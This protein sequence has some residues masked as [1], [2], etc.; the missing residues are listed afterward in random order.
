MTRYAD[1]D[2]CP[3]C[4]ATITPGA[5][6][7]G[8]CALTLRG[9]TARR[10]FVTLSQADTLL[11]TLRAA[12]VPTAVPS[13][14]P[15]A[16]T[17]ASD[18]GPAPAASPAFAARSAGGPRPGLSATSVPKLLLGLG[19]GCLL[20][21]AL[22]FLAVTWSVMGVGGR[23]ATLVAFT[24]I[25]GGLSAW[26]VGRKLRGAAESLALVG[27]GLLALDVVGADNAGWFGDPSAAALLVVVG[28]VLAGTGTAG[29][30]AVRRTTVGLTTPEVA[31]L[32]GTALASLGAGAGEWFSLSASLLAACLVGVAVTVAAHGLRMRTATVGAGLV[33]LL[34]WLALTGHSFDRAVQ[35]ASWHELWVDLEVWPLLVSCALAAGVA[36]VRALPVSARVTAASIAELVAV[37][38]LAI[39]VVDQGATEAA[40]AGI[41]ALALTG[42]ASRLLPSRWKL[43]STAVQLV[44]GL[45]LLA[46]VAGQGSSAVERLFE[47]A[48]PVWTGSGGDRLSVW[49][50]PGQPAAWLLPLAAVA[51]LGTLWVQAEASR[52]MDRVLSPVADLR[53]LAAL[54]AASLVGALALYPVPVW[55]VLAAVLLVA[56]GFTGWWLFAGSIVPL[57]PAT[58][59]MVSAVIVSLHSDGLTA[60][61]IGVVLAAGGVV[62]L[63]ARSTTLSAVAGATAASALAGLVWTVGHLL[64]V[65][66]VSVAL[67]A[68]LLLGVV[69]LVAPYAPDRWWAAGSP[70]LSRSGLE[71]GAGAAG[72]PLVMAGVA[73]A[74]QSEAATWLAV[75]LTV[76]G[77]VVTVMSLLRSD[78]RTL[79][80]AGGALL[81]LASWVRLWDIGV[82]A[83]EAYTLP[84]AAVLLVVGLLH[85][86]RTPEA[87]TMTALTPALSLALVP[88]LLWALTEPA[89]WRA[90]L[91]GLGCLALVLAGARLG[92]TA[93]MTVGAAVGGLLVLRLA[94]PYIG[95]AVPRWVLI[96]A[97]GALLIAV[98]ATWE[99]RLTDARQLMGYVRALR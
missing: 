57:A 66:P 36:A 52:L 15:A 72:V 48:G 43:S 97:A 76:A 24:A 17:S 93:P 7:C 11:A 88:S 89:G 33:A 58:I 73:L 63:R 34:G 60:V 35:H 25:A 65:E 19:A 62:H 95:E 96:G 5:S 46:L 21:A 31:V 38:A 30:L 18:V 20:V 84:S 14:T 28:A 22:V 53:V 44:A 69:A 81:A 41:A 8:T 80:W 47:A 45:G 9:E 40:L 49:A 68:L 42:L 10:L 79:G 13:V 23:T 85:L 12:S 6:S 32:V 83:P 56:V 87:G 3:D 16:A 29:A 37:V 86:R 94:A 92:W 64:E 59:F 26:F 67:V 75:Y 74:P 50:E 54:L 27:Y 61:A 77:V 2:R 98:G 99:R 90:A 82:E 91:L 55:L 1:P 4:G 78:R 39:P 71:T 70:T 51:L